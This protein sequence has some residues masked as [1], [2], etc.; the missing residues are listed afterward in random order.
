LSSRAD[1]GRAWMGGL[2]MLYLAASLLHFTHNAEY[3]ADY[4]NLPAWLSR[5]DVYLVWLGQAAVGIGG[6]LLYRTGWRVAGLLLI[7]V[8]A[9]L[10]FDGLLH[11]TRAPL[12][13]HTAAMD[14]TIWVEVAAAAVL[15]ISV[16]AL[17]S[18]RRPR[19]AARLRRSRSGGRGRVERGPGAEADRRQH[20]GQP[21]RLGPD[22]RPASDRDREGLR[23]SRC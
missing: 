15:L 14:L 23:R 1:S 11:Y 7:G 4:P 3:L 9:M 5:S 19:W 8:Y 12:E 18:R 20:A 17:G 10:G 6:Y 2:L 16:V 21:P 22:R 13:A